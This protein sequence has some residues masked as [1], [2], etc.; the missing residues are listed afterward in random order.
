LYAYDPSANSWTTKASMATARTWPTAMAINGE[1]R[2]FGGYA[3]TSSLASTEIY[4]PGTNKWSAGPAMPVATDSMGSAM[5]G[6]RVYL[7][8]GFRSTVVTNAVLVY[9]V[10]NQ[11]FATQ[12]NYPLNAEYPTTAAVGGYIYSMGGDNGSTVYANHYRFDPGIPVPV[13]TAVDEGSG[14]TPLDA[15][16]AGGWITF[17]LKALVQEWVDGVR[18]R[19]GLVIY[20]E[21]ADQM[22]INSREN[23]SR[24]PE[25]IVT[26]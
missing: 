4:S 2:V 12:L 16:F 18:P 13:A 10:V 25:L 15:T 20:T 26:Y 21:V 24:K 17:E 5:V 14:A 8:G 6:N 1:L 22:S 19:T 3:I 23:S 7:V 9:D 11:S